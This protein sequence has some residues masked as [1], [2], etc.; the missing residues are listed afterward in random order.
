MD[1]SKVIKKI[2]EEW[3]GIIMRGDTAEETYATC[4]TLIAGGAKLIEVAFTTPNVSEV[5]SKLNKRYGDE[6]VLSA[7]T[8]RTTEQARMACDSGAHVIVS[9]NLYEEVVKFAVN[10]GLVSMPGCVT[11]TEIE[12]ALRLG[13]DLIKLFPCYLFGPQYIGYINAP[14][15]E[16]KIVPAGK[17]TLDNMK[18][19][20]DNGAFAAVVGVTTEMKMGAAV[21]SK[22]W[23]DVTAA[24]RHWLERVREMKQ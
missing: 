8:V 7:G 19:Y 18:E 1:K 9:P 13:A 24:T 16:A 21:K 20:Y 5:I 22:K 23:Q 12:N 3:L 10:N 6:I 14:L 15:P 11:P 17:I 2:G 4:E